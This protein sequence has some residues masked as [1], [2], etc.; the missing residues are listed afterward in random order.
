MTQKIMTLREYINRASEEKKAIGHFNITNSDMLSG[1][2]SAAKEKNAPVIIGVSEGERD[3]MGIA[4]AVAIV[5]SYQKGK[6]G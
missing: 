6:D 4:Q 1:I 5:K 3:H 2:I